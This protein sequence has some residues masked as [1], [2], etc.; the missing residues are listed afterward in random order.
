MD[1][2]GVVTG[3]VD[4]NGEAT[5]YRV[6]YGTTTTYGLTTAAGY[7]ERAYNEAI[8]GALRRAIG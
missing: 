4:P 2:A 5:S 8:E 7:T 3:T 1:Q 6:E